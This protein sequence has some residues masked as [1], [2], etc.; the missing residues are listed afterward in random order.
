MN[1]K[2]IDIPIFPVILNVIISD[3]WSEVPKNFNIKLEEEDLN[4]EGLVG[5][6]ENSKNSYYVLLRSNT[7]LETIV[8]ES[9]HI[10][11]N[12]HKCCQIGLDWDN[13]EVLAYLTEW[14][15]KEI[16]NVTKL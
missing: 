4:H 6:V 5:E 10:A 13:D 15:F 11:T 9:I 14:I 8:H 12:I 3:D 16:N 1:Y 7:T 2:T